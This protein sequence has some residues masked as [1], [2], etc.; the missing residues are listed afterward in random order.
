MR[1]AIVFLAVFGSI[2]IILM[3]PYVGVLMWAWL[4]YMNPHRLTWGMAHDFPFAQIVGL[5]TLVA[6]LFSSEKKRIP[7]NGL[8]IVWIVFILWM[9]LTT[10]FALVP[11]YARI[12]WD[13]VM[14]IQLFSFVTI[15]LMHGRERI[16]YL[17]AVIVASIG[18]YSVKGGIF[19][20]LTG[21]TLRVYGPVG[22]FLE[23]N[24]GMGLAVVMVLPLMFYVFTLM[25]K[26][27]LRLAMLAVIGFSVLAIL[28]TQSR[29]AFLSISATVVYLWWRSRRKV[30]IGVLI[31]AI[32]PI[33]WFSMPDQWHE[34]MA[35]ITEYQSDG[36]AMGR[37][38]AWGYAYNLALDRPLLGGGYGAFDPDLFQ[39]YAPDPDD[40]HD[41]H[42]IYFEILGEHGFVGLALFLLLGIL[43]FRTTSK[44]VG[45]TRGLED[46]AWANRLAKM[47]QACLVAYAT[48]GLFLGLAYWDLYYHFV[49]LAVLLRD[50]VDRALA[51]DTAAAGVDLHSAKAST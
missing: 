7:V 11:E 46:L 19:S 22:S 44:V 20:V 25:N 31:L 23:D 49:A 3:R 42:S 45:M 10:I 47:L 30:A 13:R 37:I 21:G 34:R 39:I 40:H 1:D 26:R 43:T 35:T 38:N 8:I 29:G 2:P 9:N 27:Y 4:G 6:L 14:K 36:S 5:V 16:H 18:F 48:G 33:F 41:A 28:T 17:V 50:H 15:M 12:E 32:A 24:N 51:P